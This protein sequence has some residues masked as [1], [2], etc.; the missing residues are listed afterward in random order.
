[1]V[2]DF[3]LRWS[4]GQNEGWVEYTYIHFFIVLSLLSPLLT[5]FVA[6]LPR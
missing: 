2:L 3:L 6:V 4:G 5:I 1:M